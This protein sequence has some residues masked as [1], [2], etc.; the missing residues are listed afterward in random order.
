MADKAS[1]AS[2]KAIDI[3][4]RGAKA[5]RTNQWRYVRMIFGS[6]KAMP[7]PCMATVLTPSY[8]S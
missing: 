8:P 6:N 7:T 4:E 2:L 3:G 1:S 5:F